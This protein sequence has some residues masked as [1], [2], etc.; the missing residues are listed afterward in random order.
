MAFLQSSGSCPSLRDFW[1]IAVNGS[2]SSLASLLKSIGWILSGPTDLFVS[3]LRSFFK[4]ASGEIIRGWIIF[5]VLRP[6]VGTSPGGSSVKTLVNCFWR[7]LAF[8]ESKYLIEF[9]SFGSSR[10]GLTPVLTFSRY[11]NKNIYNIY[12]IKIKY[13]VHL[14]TTLCQ[15]F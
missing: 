4:T 15:L 13:S 14:F 10:R 8:S 7:I 12:I 3:K 2:F 6:M 5:S 9:L 11:R 1:K